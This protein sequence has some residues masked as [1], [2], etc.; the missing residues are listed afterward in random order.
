MLSVAILCGRKHQARRQKG[1]RPHSVCILKD[2]GV[3][4]R[5]CETFVRDSMLM[6]R[7]LVSRLVTRVTTSSTENGRE[8]SSQNT[9]GC[10]CS[11][12]QHGVHVLLV[13]RRK[14]LDEW[15]TLCN[16]LVTHS[17]IDMGHAY[18][19]TYSRSYYMVSRDSSLRRWFEFTISLK[20]TGDP[21]IFACATLVY[22]SSQ[23]GPPKDCNTNAA[24]WIAN[25]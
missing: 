15:N 1:G 10:S 3:N 18:T 17:M 4:G 25:V 21:K 8:L 24:T 13:L 5:R 2:F 14:Q 7:W 20:P 12:L 6:S 23:A 22:I 19:T 9:H 11:R 16:C